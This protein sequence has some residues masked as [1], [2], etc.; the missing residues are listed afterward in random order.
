MV[1]TPAT[2]AK[3]P[4]FLGQRPLEVLLLQQGWT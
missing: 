1:R 4:P 2:K 3:G